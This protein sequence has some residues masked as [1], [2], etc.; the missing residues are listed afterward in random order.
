MTVLPPNVKCKAGQVP[1]VLPGPLFLPHF[2]VD[3]LRAQ[4]D[5][6]NGCG[7]GTR[8]GSG[9]GGGHGFGVGAGLGVAPDVGQDI[10]FPLGAHRR[11]AHAWWNLF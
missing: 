1:P 6:G 10:S 2:L 4:L 3:L 9:A 5:T 8:N 7:L 11:A